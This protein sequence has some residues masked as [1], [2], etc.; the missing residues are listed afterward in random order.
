LF[1]IVHLLNSEA[2]RVV[3][4]VVMDVYRSGRCEVE[5]TDFLAAVVRAPSLANELGS[6]GANV[7]ALLLRLAAPSQGN[8]SYERL[9]RLVDE[10][11][12]GEESSEDPTTAIGLPPTGGFVALPLSAASKQL[13]HAMQQ[14]FAG[15]AS[16]SVTP[17][18]VLNVL[19]S[20]MPELAK[21]CGEFG[22]HR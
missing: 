1:E 19:L 21:L 9:Q 7:E 18:Q 16:E 2:R 22:V 5:P 4:G 20:S 8:G 3:F 13:L 17:R 14:S 12:R 6:S 10:A 11:E 15:A